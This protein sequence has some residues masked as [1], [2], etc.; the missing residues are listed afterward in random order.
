MPSGSVNV[1]GTA[2]VDAYIAETGVGLDVKIYGAQIPIT[3]EW[4]IGGT[5]NAFCIGAKVNSESGSGRMYLFFDSWFT[6]RNEW[7]LFE[8]SGISWSYPTGKQL[9]GRCSS[10]CDLPDVVPPRMPDPTDTDCI[11]G[12]YSKPDYSGP[13]EYKY[14]L[15][16]NSQTGKQ[17]PAPQD[18]SN[19]V[20]S[21][22]TFGNCKSVELLD[23]DNGVKVGSNENGF[24]YDVGGRPNLPYDL[25]NDIQGVN[26]IALPPHFEKPK[27]TTNW[28]SCCVLVIYKYDSFI[29]R[30]AEKT[31]CGG[32][33]QKFAYGGN[34]NSIEMSP[35]C[36]K[37]WIDDNDGYGDDDFHTT[38]SISDLA[39]DYAND[40][41]N[42]RLYDKSDLELLEDVSQAS[43]KMR[44]SEWTKP[45]I[46]K[47][48]PKKESGCWTCQPP[49][50][51]PLSF[52][53][54]QRESKQLVPNNH[55]VQCWKGPKSDAPPECLNNR[56]SIDIECHC[57]I[58]KERNQARAAISHKREAQEACDSCGFFFK[59]NMA[60]KAA[61][62]KKSCY[63]T[64]AKRSGKGDML[65]SC[66]PEC[67]DFN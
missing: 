34:V 49:N 27:P 46:T 43:L 3:L 26:I 14:F 7:D 12:F 47:V 22:R 56:V 33:N 16:S 42:F 52:S 60:K 63:K 15:Q 25:E 39:S 66:S 50:K 30:Q 55:K 61:R 35:G 21:M 59:K 28:Q 18:V 38:N 5:K 31:V 53:K 48:D 9:L 36:S 40:I 58:K 19:N 41:A 1:D 37:V 54:A 29:G 64:L 24:I 57:A 67:Q 11:V 62:C 13:N 65:E 2:S 44:V 23:D 8:W 32:G 51:D 17:I 4:K 10:N 20:N 45:G 6:G